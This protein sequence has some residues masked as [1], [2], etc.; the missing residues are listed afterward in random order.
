[1]TE[2]LQ[3]RNNSKLSESMTFWRVSERQSERA[4]VVDKNGFY[5]LSGL[6]TM[7][8]RKKGLRW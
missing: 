8:H 3:T 5:N 2:Q 4:I 7:G 1:M 6:Y